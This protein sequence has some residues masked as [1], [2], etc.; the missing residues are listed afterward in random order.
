VQIGGGGL[1]GGITTA[2]KA[3]K[4]SCKIIGVQTENFPDAH[5]IFTKTK[6]K[7]NKRYLPCIADGI[8][9]KQP[10]SMA[11]DIVKKYVDEIVTVSNDEIEKAIL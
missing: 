2:I 6:L 5:D 9:V 7:T 3:I 8:Q 1:I 11:M 10:S 4:P